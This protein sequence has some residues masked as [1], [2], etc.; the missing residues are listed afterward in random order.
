MATMATLNNLCALSDSATLGLT[1]T[2]YNYNYG[3]RNK[4]QPSRSAT[5]GLN[6]NC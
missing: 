4:L 1:T 3:G 2:N 6:K 5:L